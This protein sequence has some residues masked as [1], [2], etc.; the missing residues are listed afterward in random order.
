MLAEGNQQRMQGMISRLNQIKNQVNGLRSLGNPQIA[1]N[2]MMSNNPQ[3]K[4]AMDYVNSNGGDPKQAL[5][6]LLTENG[7]NP[8]EIMNMISKS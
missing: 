4:Q 1:L 7:V 3:M 2:H 5:N 6:K 8:Q